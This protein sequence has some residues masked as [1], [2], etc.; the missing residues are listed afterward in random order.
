MPSLWS[1][2]LLAPLGV[3]ATQNDNIMA[4]DFYASLD[5]VTLVDLLPVAPD[6]G[7]NRGSLTDVKL[8]NEA[9]MHWAAG[10]KSI[11]YDIETVGLTLR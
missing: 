11:I 8:K 1:L 2:L 7:E 4:P 10:E 3:L 9:T 6:A 5:N